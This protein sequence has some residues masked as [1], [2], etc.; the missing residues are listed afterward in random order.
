MGFSD[1]RGKD[2]AIIRIRYIAGFEDALFI[3]HAFVKKTQ[4]TSR[5]D[6]ELVRERL[7]LIMKERRS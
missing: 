2:I 4:K 1:A 6:L 7:G 3:P 5:R